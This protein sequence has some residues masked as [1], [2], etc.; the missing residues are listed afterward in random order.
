MGVPGFASRMRQY[1]SY[2]T[3]GRRK[4]EPTTRAVI[5]GPSLAHH[6]F[7][8]IKRDAAVGS[9]IVPQFDYAELGK[10]T[11]RWLD[12]LS[13]YGFD[14]Y[15]RHSAPKNCLILLTAGSEGIY[16]DGALPSH[17][18]DIRIERLQ[19]YVTK[20]A[21]YKAVHDQVEKTSRKDHTDADRNQNLHHLEKARNALPPPPF[22]VFA[23]VEALM[24]SRYS[25]RTWV[26]NG[27][28]DA[29]C[30]TTA[31]RIHNMTPGTTVAIFTND[32]DLILYDIGRNGKVVMLNDVQVRTASIGKVMEGL[33][34]HPSALIKSSS[35]T[36]QPLTLA[37]WKMRDNHQ[38]SFKQ[39]MASCTAADQ[40]DEGHM[41]FKA[42][43]D[44][45]QAKKEFKKRRA[46]RR[47]GHGIPLLDSR[48]SELICAATTM[49]ETS[50]H[51][52]DSMH[53]GVD[54]YLPA[55]Y[56]DPARSTA[57]KI[58][59]SFRAAAKAIVVYACKL[60]ASI[61]EYRRS[62]LSVRS[63]EMEQP[64]SEALR[65]RCKLW[66]QQ[67]CAIFQQ[68]RSLDVND[69][70][71][72]MVMQFALSDTDDEGMPSPDVDDVTTVLSGAN[73]ATWSA[74]HLSAQFQAEY[75]SLRMLKQVLE[76]MQ[77]FQ[78]SKRDEDD[79]PHNLR[80]ALKALP[81]IAAFCDENIHRRSVL[82]PNDWNA[83]V[84]RHF[85]LLSSSSRR[86][87]VQTTVSGTDAIKA[88]DGLSS[89]NPIQ[90]RKKRKAVPKPGQLRPS[91]DISKGTRPLLSGNPFAALGD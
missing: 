89:Q 68:E 53:A 86:Q 34:F 30:A 87:T 37:A 31:L 4:D 38:L 78:G 61:H 1:G 79:P 23:I 42:M 10:A 74:V 9:G 83:V 19:G 62:G 6:I 60:Q 84:K 76:W 44:T 48:A 50:D 13:Q 25:D 17:K 33:V 66:T 80:E 54:M 63:F 85:P 88:Q 65:E 47:E 11:I 15:C 59:Q 77:W 7:N 52:V 12:E 70:W 58:G 21:H 32:S 27:E 8:V 75:Y 40:C 43:Y 67:L 28:A 69:Q 57:W 64:S 29:F 72:L 46:M 41:A 56:E 39:A 16:F 3:I 71:R 81:D 55:L 2:E 82:T 45:K 18:K 22:L 14:M 36:G 26:V 51:A 24:D 90:Q 35:Q 49:H 5:D 20:L 73:L 91:K